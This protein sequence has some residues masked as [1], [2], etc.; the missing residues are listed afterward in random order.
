MATEKEIV[1]LVEDWFTALRS[2]NVENVMRL[3]STSAILLPTLKDKV[4]ETPKDI[5]EY[6]EG[7]FLKVNPD[8]KLKGKTHPKL[9]GHIA[10]HS[11]LYEF[12]I[13]GPP[14]GGPVIQLNGSITVGSEE[15][16]F[17]S[18]AIEAKPKAR[19]ASTGSTASPRIRTVARFSFVYHKAKTDD[20]WLIVEHHSSVLPEKRTDTE[21]KWLESY[22]LG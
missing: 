13:D 16:E 7:T 15:Y 11:G 17:K 10:T 14:T 18:A 12:E 3:Y 2:L 21:S 6:F 5:A 1:A 4:M 22:F 9:Y 19:Q 20:K 8:G